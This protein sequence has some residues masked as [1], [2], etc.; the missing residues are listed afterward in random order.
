[1]KAIFLIAATA[2]FTMAAYADAPKPALKPARTVEATTVTSTQDPAV[3][4]TLPKEARYVGADRWVLYDVAD[5]EI[6][7]F[8]E[9][10]V[11]KNVKRFYWIQFEG[12]IPSKPD[13]KYKPYDKRIES[14]GGLD[15]YVRARFGPSVETPRPNSDSERVVRLLRDNGYKLPPHLMNARFIHYLD[16]T[17]RKE[18]MI[19]FSEDLA[20]TGHTSEQLMDGNA[21]IAAW[22]PIAEALIQRAK[23]AITLMPF[24]AGK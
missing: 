23:A 11:E 22:T 17:M 10:D 19:I 16:Q 7:L 15:F 9:A 20:T 12:Y 2:L 18:L 13:L 6:H 21:P 3:R 4:V 14:I 1:M 8:V 5:C 24:D